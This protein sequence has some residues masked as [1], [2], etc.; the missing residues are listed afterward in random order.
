MIV[1]T[2]VAVAKNDVIGDGNDIPWRLSTDLKYFK[3]TTTG[4]HV[5]MGRKTFASMGR[6]LPNRTNIVLTRDP[7]FIATGIIVA[8][9]IEEAL[10]IAYNNEEEEVFIMGGGEIY[11]QSQAYWDKVYLTRVMLEPKGDIIF[12]LL[13]PDEWKR[14][15]AEAH[16]AGEKDECDFVIE[17]YERNES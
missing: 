15:S 11:K 10:T 4:H 8:H 9:S 12:P 16:R 3:K 5:I 6:P 2:I 13:K 17:V 7:H 14:I 1:S